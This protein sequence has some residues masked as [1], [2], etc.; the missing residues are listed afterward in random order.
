M[1]KKYKPVIYKLILNDF[2]YINTAANSSIV[3]VYA[4]SRRFYP[5]RLTNEDIP[6]Q[7]TSK[8]TI[9]YIDGNHESDS[10]KG[11]RDRVQA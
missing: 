4:F 6:L 3:Y 9:S 7:L 2:F 5:K 1:V 10:V 8:L 11:D